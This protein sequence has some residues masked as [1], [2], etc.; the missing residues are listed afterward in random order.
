[1][2]RIVFVL[3]L[4]APALAAPSSD[5]WQNK[6][7]PRLRSEFSSMTRSD[8]K[9][10]AG[11]ELSASEAHD[12]RALYQKLHFVKTPAVVPALPQPQVAPAPPHAP[13][14]V[15]STP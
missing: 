14:A 10:N 9:P 12:L 8:W 6:M 3:L 7:S 4:M 5:A 2:M 1:M 13:E 15:P 11:V